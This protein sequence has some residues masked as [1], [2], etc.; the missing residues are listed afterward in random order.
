MELTRDE[1]EYVRLFRLARK[2][3]A[4]VVETGRSA[5][6]R[7]AAFHEEYEIDQQLQAVLNRIQLASRVF[8]LLSQDLYESKP[9]VLDLLMAEAAR[10]FE[11]H[12]KAEVGSPTTE[13]TTH[14]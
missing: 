2:V 8:A 6:E 14:D 5:E 1:Y 11:R 10:R 13:G 3:H 7:L 4:I 12:D 9:T